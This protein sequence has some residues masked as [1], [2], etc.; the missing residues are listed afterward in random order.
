MKYMYQIFSFSIIV[1]SILSMN[2]FHLS[3]LQTISLMVI[4]SF[5]SLIIIHFIKKVI[6]LNNYLAI[7]FIIE[8]NCNKITF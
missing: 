2:Y 7:L 6:I 3:T 4:L 1:I 8:R 5:I